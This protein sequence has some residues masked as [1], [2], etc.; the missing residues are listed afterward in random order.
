LLRFRYDPYEAFVD[1]HTHGYFNQHQ[2]RL[3]LH[4]DVQ[5]SLNSS[6]THPETLRG[7]CLLQ[8]PYDLVNRLTYTD[9]RTYLPDDILVKVDR[10]SMM[11]SLEVRAPFLDHRIMDFSFHRIPGHLKVKGMTLKYLLKKLAKKILPRELNLNRKWGFSIPVS[12]WFRGTL[13]HELKKKLLED[14]SLFF[15]R[16]Y[17]ERLLGEH[18]SGIDHSGR[19]FTL[20]IFSLWEKES[21]V[22]RAIEKVIEN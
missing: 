21:L 3:L 19:L 17:V 16:D 22:E 7:E 14:G 4:K 5:A 8:N 11:V 1:R 2:R 13:S 6:F 15:Q 18:Q 9:F 10:M 20:L 12:E